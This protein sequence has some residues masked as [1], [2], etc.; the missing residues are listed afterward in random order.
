M[1]AQTLWRR[2]SVFS[3]L[4]GAILLATPTFAAEDPAQHYLVTRRNSQLRRDLSPEQ[5]AQSPNDYRGV[6]LEIEG[7]LVGIAE[8]EGVLPTLMLETKEHGSV[9]L[10]MSRIPYWLSSGAQIRVLVIVMGAPEGRILV[11]LPDMEIVAVAPARDVA[12]IE[13]RERQRAQQAANSKPITASAPKTTGSYAPTA[14]RPPRMVGKTTTSSTTRSLS[15]IASRSGSSRYARETGTGQTLQ[16]IVAEGLSE[17][18]QAVYPQYKAFIA[19]HNK[20]LT[21]QQAGDIAYGV[22][23]FC[24]KL[25]MDPR[26]MIA[27]MMAESDFRPG[28]TSR[29]GAM[30]VA[31]LMPD[32]VQRLGL[33]NPYDPLQNI[34]GSVFLMKERLSK[35]SGSTDFK[36]ANMRHIVLALA[37]YNAGMGAVKRYGGVPPYRETQNYVKKIERYYRELTRNDG[38]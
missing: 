38:Q 7:R 26:L 37:S 6:T 10:R 19:R 28:L 14:P 36:D 17:G 30:G 11:G 3:L 32:E 13:E 35:Y 4:S 34:A 21:D 1:K 16:Q 15:K 29:A 24:E 33:S 8:S 27:L 18:A 2:F 20:R 31:Q 9:H 22:L 23:K 5:I 12:A 25:D